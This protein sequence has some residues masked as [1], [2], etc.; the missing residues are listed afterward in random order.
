MNYTSEQHPEEGILQ[1]I[2]RVTFDE[3][4]AVVNTLV[5]EKI[6]R[7]LSEAEIIVLKGA[8]DDWNYEE[9]AQNSPYTP[10]YL[11]RRLGPQLWD[12][13]TATIGNGERVYKKNLRNYLEQ[14]VIT[15][16]QNRTLI[17]EVNISPSVNSKH[18]LG[19]KLP[20]IRRFYGRNQELALL[21][22]LVTKQRCIALIGVPGIG[23]SALA[24]KLIEL[25]YLE[26][27]HNFDR[28]IWKSV[29]HAPL[30][31]DLVADI[32][33]LIQPVESLSDFPESTQS[34]ITLLI[35]YLQAHR[36]LIVLDEFDELFQKSSIEQCLEYRTFFRRLVEEQ[37]STSLLLTGRVLPSEFDS[38]I[39]AKRPIQYLKI[40]GLDTD[41]A[42]QL[43]ASQGLTDTQKCLDLITTYS[44]NPL[45]LETVLERINYFFA[46]STDTFFENQTTFVNSEIEAMLEQMFSQVLNAIQKEI[47]IYLAE[48][49]ASNHKSA[50]FTQILNALNNK[51]KT[52]VSTSEIVNALEKLEKLSLIESIRD[53]STGKVNFTIQPVI[54]KYIRTDP[55]GLVHKFHTSQQIAIAS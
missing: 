43:L 44:G 18:I 11:Q 24:A 15:N 27:Q 25:L 37:N 13:L 19:S 8:W 14:A 53:V 12:V 34:R 55:Q 39:R 54:K 49:V 46:G 28:F 22:D 3:A 51:R 33:E 1:Q 20:D 41:A 7:H 31:H 30:V 36:Y 29:S 48:D 21:K 5:S 38:L 23:K 32:I 2:P 16:H 10:N 4:L 45:Q 47:M 17:Q 40:K 6:G 50:S 35:K 26:S 52:S 9:I 42:I